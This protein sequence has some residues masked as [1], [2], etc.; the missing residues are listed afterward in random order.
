MLDRP[1]Q[2]NRDLL[3]TRKPSRGREAAVRLRGHPLRVGLCVPPV[4]GGPGQVPGH[5]WPRFCLRPGGEDG[6]RCAGRA[7][8]CA[9]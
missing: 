8:L 4:P 2:V 6:R 9:R 7:R 5:S 3:S 1:H